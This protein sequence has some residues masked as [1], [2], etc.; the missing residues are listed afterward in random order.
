MKRVWNSHI[1][2]TVVNMCL[3]GKTLSLVSRN[4]P[5]LCQRAEPS[6]GNAGLFCT[7]LPQSS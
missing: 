6:S 3:P 2:S 1:A 5:P 7:H 4:L